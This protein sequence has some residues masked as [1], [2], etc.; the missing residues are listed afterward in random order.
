MSGHSKW[1]T[2][3][4]QKAASDAKRSQI[5]TKLTNL[6]T[7]A[8]RTGANPETNFKLRMAIEKARAFSVP[9]DNIERAIKRGSGEGSDENLEEIIYEGFGPEKVAVVVECVTDNKNRTYSTI[10]HLFNQY[11]GNLGSSGSVLWQFQRKGVIVLEMTNLTEAEQLEIIEAGAED[12]QDKDQQIFIYTKPEDL[13]KVKN[14]LKK[15]PIN[16][17][18]LIWQAKD[19]LK[20]SD[21]SK[22]EEFFEKLDEL[23]EVN[24][25]YTNA[26]I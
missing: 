1:A 26:D 5:F 20:I 19:K 3:K 11:G 16:D 15:F 6:I 17:T 10:K 21:K 8:A 7:I 23:D 14:S 22:L 18:Y 9:K 24:E 2:T 13:E 12:L 4:R 25:I